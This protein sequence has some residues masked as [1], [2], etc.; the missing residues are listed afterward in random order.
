MT[1]I[2]TEE[3]DAYITHFKDVDITL[4]HDSISAQPLFAG[5]R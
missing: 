2:A 4:I 5:V 3:W 1:V